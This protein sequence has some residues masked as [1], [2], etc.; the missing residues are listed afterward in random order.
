MQVFSAYF[1]TSCKDGWIFYLNIHS[2]LKIVK[3]S[4]SVI[5]FH[6]SC[7]CLEKSPEFQCKASYKE[8]E[9]MARKWEGSSGISGRKLG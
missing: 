7:R 3:G 6:T 5:S 2:C 9:K 1:S 8:E 4:S